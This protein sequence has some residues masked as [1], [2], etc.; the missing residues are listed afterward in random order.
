MDNIVYLKNEKLVSG[1]IDDHDDQYENRGSI[2]DLWSF[3]QQTTRVLLVEDDPMTRHLVRKCLKG[4]CMFATSGTAQNAIETCQ[5]YN[6]DVVFL[7]LGLPDCSG[8]VVLDWL[9]I[10]QPNVAV[11]LFTN[12]SDYAFISTLMSNGASGYIAK[13]FSRDDFVQYINAEKFI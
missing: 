8:S 5:S 3:L 4:E 12:T 6:P 9:K 1:H 2:L 13:P 11:V 7:D 10:N